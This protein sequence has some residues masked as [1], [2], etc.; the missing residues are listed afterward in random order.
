MRTMPAR[1]RVR[2]LTAALGSTA[3]VLASASPATANQSTS[4]GVLAPAISPAPASDTLLPGGTLAPGRAIV[5]SDGI[6]K[7]V[8]QTDGNLVNYD[9]IRRPVWWSGTAGSPGARLVMQ[10]D[11]NLT[12][13]TPN[14]NPIW[15][16]ATDNNPG[17]VLQ[18]DADGVPIVRGLNGLTIWRQGTLTGCSASTLCVGETLIAGKSLISGNGAAHLDIATNGRIKISDRSG[19]LTRI[20]PKGSG[21]DHLMLQQDGNL[22]LSTSTGLTTWS[23]GTSGKGISFAS[24]SNT[25][26]LRLYRWDGFLVWTI[27]GSEGITQS[28]L[29]PGQRLLPGQ[30]ISSPAGVFRLVAQLDGNLV[31]IGP[32]GPSWQSGT[33]GQGAARLDLQPGGNLVLSTMAGTPL[34]WSGTDGLSATRLLVTDDGV[35][36]LVHPNGQTVWA[37]GGTLPAAIVARAVSQDQF[38]AGITALPSSSF[39]NPYSALLG[40]GSSGCP[41]GPGPDGGTMT[42]SDEEWCSDFVTWVWGGAGA[43]TAGLTAWAFNFVKFGQAHGTFKAGSTNNPHLGDA[44]IWGDASVGYGQHV[45]VVSAVVG[46]HISVVNGDWAHAVI[47]PGFID[48]ATYTVRGYSIIGYVSPVHHNR[49]SVRN[50]SPARETHSPAEISRQGGG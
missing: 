23:S 35:I 33:G 37:T 27:G 3:F 43:E 42:Y 31:V 38:G 26:I 14:D 39:C 34:W 36:E 41:S 45:G 9:D 16:S 7:L 6:S 10:P 30:Q 17:A 20:G 12:I 13:R 49:A 2:R 48:P 4:S 11:G 44:V 28:Q 8:M 24:F 15:S 19:V 47:D 32:F 5:S 40:R 29:R 1:T 50:T 21:A 46:S 18:I 22:V 25:G